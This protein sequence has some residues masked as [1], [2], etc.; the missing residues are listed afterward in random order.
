MDF[1]ELKKII[2]IASQ[3]QDFQTESKNLENLIFS[4]HK[5]EFLPLIFKPEK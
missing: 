2:K 1:N 3:K 5:N 4:L